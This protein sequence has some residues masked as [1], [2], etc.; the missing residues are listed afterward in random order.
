MRF[1]D[2]VHFEPIQLTSQPSWANVLLF[3]TEVF[4]PS[5]RS[6]FR[7]CPG[8]SSI[9]IR[10]LIRERI[11]KGISHQSRTGPKNQPATH[12]RAK[13][14]ETSEATYFCHF[15]NSR[16]MVISFS[17]VSN[18]ARLRQSGE[19]HE[20][21]ADAGYINRRHGEAVSRVD[22]IFHKYVYQLLLSLNSSHSE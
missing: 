12:Q 19:T 7:K 5:W 10:K 9:R 8:D 1:R 3:V 21:T 20:S 4:R 14:T 11:A 22:T 18:S 15:D 6:C 17:Q 16:P 13:T 2:G